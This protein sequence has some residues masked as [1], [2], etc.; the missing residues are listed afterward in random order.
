MQSH[1]MTQNQVIKSL[2]VIR[3]SFEGL[4]IDLNVFLVFLWSTKIMDSRALKL[5]VNDINH[6][7][8]GLTMTLDDRGFSPQHITYDLTSIARQVS[9]TNANVFHLQLL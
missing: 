5:K 7:H 3:E 6:C 8:F 9:F 4:F 1:V 2:V